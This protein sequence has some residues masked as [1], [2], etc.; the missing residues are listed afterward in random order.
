MRRAGDWWLPGADAYFAPFLEAADG[1]QLDHL[2]AALAHCRSWRCAIDGGAHVGTWTVAMAMRFAH[3]YAFEP[4]ADTFS[5]L[6]RNVSERG[7]TNVIA[8][9]VALGAESGVCVVTDDVTRVGNTGARYLKAL[10]GAGGSRVSVLALDEMGLTT[11]D[12]VKLD[13]EG[14]EHFALRG[15][16]QTIRQCRPVVVVEEKNFGGRYG[17]A[18]GAASALLRDWGAREVARAGK[19]VIFIFD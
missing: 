16:E 6:T 18:A 9:N 19:D 8:M 4:A 2:E 15:A 17:Q 13:L 1:F 12:F 3:V 14:Y 5:C 11:V 10:N 7:L